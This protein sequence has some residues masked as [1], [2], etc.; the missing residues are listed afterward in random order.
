MFP[1]LTDRAR[2][3][4][5]VRSFFAERNVLEVDVCALSRHAPIALNIDVIDAHVSDK[6]RGFLHTSPEYAMKRLLAT[7][8]G[9]IYFLGHVFRKGE[10]G[11]LHNPEFTMAEWYRLGFTLSQLMEETCQF[12]FLFFSPLPI[13]RLSYRDAFTQYLS[14]NYTE[15][16]LS[17]LQQLAS[18][19]LPSDTTHWDRS[20]YLH[21][22]LSHFIEPHLGQ[23]ELTL[24]TDYPPSEAALACTT[25]RNQELVAERFEIYYQGVELANGYHEL[26]DPIELRRRFHED[27]EQRAAIG[28]EAYPLDEAFLSALPQMPDCCGVSVGFDRALMLRNQKRSLS[29]ILP[30][31]WV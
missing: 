6:E 11:R 27:N 9:D 2:L 21:L 23:S 20:H 12:L 30:F 15:A 16:P 1:A 28:K 22:L 17:H 3:L 4:A 19:Y 10:I 25:I 8:S 14:L 26:V 5:A 18:P 13:R 29:E 24:L 7:G 31:T